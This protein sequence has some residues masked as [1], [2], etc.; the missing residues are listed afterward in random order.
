ME[1]GKIYIV[2]TADVIASRKPDNA[3]LMEKLPEKIKMIN[4]QY[5]PLVPL[6]IFAGDEIQGVWKSRSPIFSILIDFLSHIYPLRLR[7]GIGIGEIYGNIEDKSG[8]MQGP[9]FENAR[10][11]LNQAGRIRQRIQAK[12]WRD[13]DQMVNHLLDLMMKIM[14]RWD[15]ITFRRYQKY[16][17]LGTIKEIAR[18]E[19]VSFEAVNKTINRYA[20]RE[21]SNTLN[22]L[23][24]L[25]REPI[26]P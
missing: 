24:L 5:H 12:G 17:H 4:Q 16:R 20:I 22:Y 14:E 15:A 26:Q 8:A 1:T 2:L 6:H 18:N 23:D 3:K 21:I 13:H 25:L 19:K 9:A 11:A 10:N 7:T